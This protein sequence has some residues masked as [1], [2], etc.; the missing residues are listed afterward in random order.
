MKNRLLTKPPMFTVKYK[1]VNQFQSTTFTLNLDRTFN[2][3]KILRR[4][5][6]G[7]D[8][9]GGTILKSFFEESLKN[10]L[11]N[12]ISNQRLLL[13]VGLSFM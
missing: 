9:T 3:F 13:S 11:K 10:S 5:C 12:Q 7:E 6:K 4:T 2:S 8:T 1:S